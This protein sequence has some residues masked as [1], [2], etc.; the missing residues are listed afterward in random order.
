M[1]RGSEWGTIRSSVRERQWMVCRFQFLKLAP[2]Q[3][4]RTLWLLMHGWPLGRRGRFHCSHTLRRP[5]VEAGPVRFWVRTVW[6]VLGSVIHVPA[7]AEGHLNI[8]IE[9]GAVGIHPSLPMSNQRQPKLGGAVAPE[10][11]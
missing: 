4:G 5:W 3:G 11:P 9:L 6:Y 1:R 2:A 8:N 7:P 10:A